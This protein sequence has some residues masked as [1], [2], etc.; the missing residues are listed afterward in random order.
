MR[1]GKNTW[2]QIK[3]IHVE[4]L[5]KALKAD[6][7]VQGVSKGA[8]HP[9][10]HPDGRIVTIHWHPKKTFNPSLLKALLEKIGWSERDL[11]RLK[12]IK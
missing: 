1:Y 10:R 6:G 3:G 4:R 11:R 12:L 8:I 5:V 2:T 9:Y 7:W